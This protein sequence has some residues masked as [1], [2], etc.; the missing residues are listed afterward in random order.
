M[1]GQPRKRNAEHAFAAPPAAASKTKEDRALG[2]LILLRGPG[3][4]GTIENRA[5][6]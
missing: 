4:A 5:Q 2:A 6:T 3:R 1:Q